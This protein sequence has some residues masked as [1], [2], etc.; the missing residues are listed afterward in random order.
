MTATPEGGADSEEV[1]VEE[2]VESDDDDDGELLCLRGGAP[3]SPPPPSSL[4]QSIRG[5]LVFYCGSKMKDA[6]TQREREKERDKRRDD[7]PNG[8]LDASANEHW[9]L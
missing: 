2:E 7:L 9:F 6:K 5:G 3:P 8:F 1:E 4:R